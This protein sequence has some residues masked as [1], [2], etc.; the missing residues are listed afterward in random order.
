MGQISINHAQAQSLIEILQDNI[1]GEQVLFTS[2]GRSG[3]YVGFNLRS[4]LIKAS[5]EIEEAG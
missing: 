5:G 4:F 2:Q 3:L 1:D